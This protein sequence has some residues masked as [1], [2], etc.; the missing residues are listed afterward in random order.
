MSRIDEEDPGKFVVQASN[1]PA[2]FQEELSINSGF[3]GVVFSSKEPI[4]VSNYEKYSVKSKIMEMTGSRSLMVSPILIADNVVG[5]IHVV[6]QN[7]YYFSYENYKL[8]QTLSGHIGLAMANATLHAEVQRMVITDNLTGLYVRHYLDGQ[9]KTMQKQDA[10][11]TL[12]LVDIDC[13]KQINDTFGHQV[14]DSILIQVS[15]IV[16]SMIREQDITARWG[17]EELAIYLPVTSKNEG[18]QMADEIRTAIMQKTSPSVT[19]S[20]GVADWKS[21]DDKISV[22][23]LF[24]KADMAL[25]EAKRSGKNRVVQDGTLL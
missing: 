9:I 3:S 11:G 22:E 15:D 1:F 2:M 8:L 13:F 12:I 24:Y 20:C 16:R 4:I 23:S 19:V 21:T 17:G 18:M 25:Y 5:I 14:G 7:P 6:H 10:I